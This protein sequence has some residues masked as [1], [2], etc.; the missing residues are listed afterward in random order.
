MPMEMLTRFVLM[1]RFT[2]TT[3]ALELL[4]T[5]ILS[6]VFWNHV[7]YLIISIALL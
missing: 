2:L 5:K 4:F 3:L 6:F 1:A 7:V